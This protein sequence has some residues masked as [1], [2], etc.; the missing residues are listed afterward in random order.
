MNPLYFLVAVRKALALPKRAYHRCEYC[1]APESIF[2]VVFE[3]E[4]VI[5]VSAGGASTADNLALAC[6]SCNSFKGSR[7]KYIDLESSE[8]ER[9][10][11]P[12][13]D[14]W[15]E[16]FLV[17][18]ESSV[19]LALSSIGRVTVIAFKMNGQAQITAR[20]LWIQLGLFP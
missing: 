20:Q 1:H 5:P 19:I 18:S 4:H 11:H 8:E 17:D 9:F 10:Y 14:R 15:E 3:V 6:R 2:N 16:H 13:R 12:R 7:S